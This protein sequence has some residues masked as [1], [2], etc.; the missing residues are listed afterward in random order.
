MLIQPFVENGLWHGLRHKDGLKELFINFSSDDQHIFVIIEDNGIGRGAAKS[1]NHN[2]DVKKQSL[3]IKISEEQLQMV[4]SL[5]E[6]KS[7]IKIEDL[8]SV[9]GA[10]AGTRVTLTIP[11]LERISRF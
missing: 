1:F 7:D 2:S 4:S 10:P 8:F 5:S 6:Q 11:I 9:T 3:G